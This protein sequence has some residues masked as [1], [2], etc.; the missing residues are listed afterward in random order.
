M[1]YI[2]C[3]ILALL[4]LASCSE[5]NK[6]DAVMKPAATDTAAVSKGS[7]F[8]VTDYLQ[9]QI[10]QMKDAGNNPILFTKSGNRTDS[11]W[12]SME[13]MDSLLQEF[14]QPSIDSS[15]YAA[16]FKENKFEDASLNMVTLSYDAQPN[17]AAN[18]PW[19]HW[20][21]Y[22]D[23]ESGEVKRI[24]MVKYPS[25]KLMLQL[26]FKAGEYWKITSIA[27]GSDAS[28]ISE[29]KLMLKY[30]SK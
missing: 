29:K 1:K 3:P 30:D 19:A 11:S 16:Y 28:V 4:I 27:T 13:A 15:S 9:G 6:E 26:Q 10:L 23:P 24:Y 21:I 12:L 18:I 5:Q 8:P 17:L 22:I 2:F 25:D 14:I 20:D 7:F